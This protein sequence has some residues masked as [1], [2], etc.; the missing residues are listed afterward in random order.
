M[1]TNVRRVPGL[2]FRR[3]SGFDRS[4]A[5]SNEYPATWG[6]AS[7]V[8]AIRTPRFR[9][10]LSSKSRYVARANECGG[11]QG[12]HWLNCAGSIKG[13]DRA[14]FTPLKKNS[15]FLACDV[16]ESSIF[17]QVPRIWSRSQERA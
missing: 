9:D 8:A 1:L 16:R 4:G 5:T 10:K 13:E 6:T 14:K 17:M 12:F 7:A 3:T 15:C 2:S 11:A